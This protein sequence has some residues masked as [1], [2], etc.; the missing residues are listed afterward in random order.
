MRPYHH[1]VSQF[2]T[3]LNVSCIQ[4]LENN[5]SLVFCIKFSQESVLLFKFLS[6]LKVVIKNVAAYTM[7]LKPY[8]RKSLLC[9][10]VGQKCWLKSSIFIK[11]IYTIKI[12]LNHITPPPNFMGR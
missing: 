4:L 8:N 12:C 6:P 10:Q 11:I 5:N 2:K 7:T 3:L 9:L 1:V